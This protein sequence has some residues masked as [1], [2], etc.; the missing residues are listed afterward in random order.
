MDE[1]EEAEDAHEEGITA[2]RGVILDGS[3][4]NW[5]KPE[6]AL[7]DAAHLRQ[8]GCLVRILKD[9]DGEV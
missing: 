9:K 5:A 3:P 4:L 6:A 8:F 2:K 1:E 7:V